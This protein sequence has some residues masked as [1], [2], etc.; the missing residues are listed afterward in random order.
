VSDYC[1]DKI[2]TLTSDF[3]GAALPCECNAQGSLDFACAEYG[4]QCRCKPNV[5]GRNCD[6]CAPGYF[7]FPDC[8]RCKCG[9]NHQCDER[10]GQCFCPRFVE[11]L[12]CDRCVQYAYGYDPLIGCQL[13]GCSINGS[14]DGEQRCD[15]LNGQCLC[16]EDVGGRR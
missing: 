15:P 9:V 2:F 1:R 3:N 10:S 7:N 5:I 11:G 6:R 16:K 4:G 14:M 8:M 12:A 13:C